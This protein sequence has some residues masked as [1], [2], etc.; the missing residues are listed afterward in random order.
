MGGSFDPIHTA[1]LIMADTAREAL[2]LDIMLFLPAGKQPLKQGKPA[3]PAEARVQMIRLAIEGNPAFALS[4]VDVDREGLSYTADS[5]AELRAEWGDRDEAHLWFIIGSDSLLTLPNWH[6]PDRILAQARLAVVRRPTF[7]ADMAALETQV[8]GL[9][10]AVDWVDAPLLEISATDIR[11]R[12]RTGRSIR[13]RV[14]EPVR[15]YIE[16]QGLY[17]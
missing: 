10:S 17:I 5:L 2:K 14:T 15:L 3:T 11:E 8:P 7:T 4:R 1:H 16:E 9:S 12:V 13:Y 6:D